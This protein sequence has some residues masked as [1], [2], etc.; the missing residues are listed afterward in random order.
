MHSFN[1]STANSGA[2]HLNEFDF[3]LFKFVVSSSEPKFHVVNL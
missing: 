2:N 1:S 3:S